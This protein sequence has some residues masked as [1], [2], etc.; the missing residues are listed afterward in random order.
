MMLLIGNGQV[1]TRDPNQ[2]YIKDGAILV[3]GTTIAAIGST[4]SL[5]AT[6]R[7][8]R[9]IE[10]KGGIIMP[11][12]I[13]IH[14]HIYS[15][16]A[17]G[18][19]IKGYAPQGFLDI[20]NGLWWNIDRH[21]DTQL[22]Y[23]SALGTYID[24]IKNGVTTIFDHH[25][26]YGEIK[27]SLFAIGQAATET[28]IRSCLCYEVS[29]RDGDTKAKDA[30]LENERWITYAQHDTSDMLAGMMG[31]HAQFTISDQTFALAAEHTPQGAGYHIHVAEGIEDVE[32]CLRHYN[33]R[34]VDR[35]YDWNILGPQTLLAHCIYVNTHEMG[36]IK[37]T[38]TMVVHNPESNMANACGCPPTL[39]MV[40]RRILTGLGTD[41]YTQDMIESY[42]V[43]NLLH[44]HFLGDPNAGFTEIPEMLF[45][46]NAKIANR[47]FKTPL[48]ILK[49]GAAAD[50]IVTDYIPPT[51]FTP[52]SLNS[53][54]LFGMTGRSVITT[55]A[56]GQVLM[57]DRIVTTL[58]EDEIFARIRK[59][60]QELSKRLN[61]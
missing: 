10:A 56:N 24:C 2:P 17:R 22:T 54:I 45:T 59:G 26:S 55:I 47:Y 11:G 19:F 13:N 25:A 3:D 30:I 5:R 51:P 46:N 34:I 28:G 50:I 8:A 35:L 1:Y 7:Q 49:P 53:H 39:D 58:D 37:D 36:L 9:Y 43:A 32:H 18:L 57:Q 33:K 61:A 41:G 40:R 6:Y 12:L 44:K 29:N 21:L 27:D 20:L 14:D 23:L 48:G 31:L 42:K 16:M 52:S 38:D 4:D 60:A 15:Y